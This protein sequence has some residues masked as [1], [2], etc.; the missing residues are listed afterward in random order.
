MILLYGHLIR[1]FIT[2]VTIRKNVSVSR[3]LQA[4]EAKDASHGW[5][6]ICKSTKI[7]SHHISYAI[8]P[9]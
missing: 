5:N 9:R 4:S 8:G 7:P 6:V 2:A 3:T 1:Q